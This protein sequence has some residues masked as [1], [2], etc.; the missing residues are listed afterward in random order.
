VAKMMKILISALGIF[1]LT[2]SVAFSFVSKEERFAKEMAKY[3]K[4]NTFESCISPQQI[5][6]TNVLDD[7]HILFE[8]RGN[9]YLLNTLDHKCS[10]LGFER[11]IS[12]TVRGGRLCNTDTVSVFDNSLGPISSCFLGKFEI[13]EKLPKDSD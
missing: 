10:R 9:K 1:N 3:S 5:K 2:L 4:T 12:Y 8:M 6:R 11:S 7:N 13:L